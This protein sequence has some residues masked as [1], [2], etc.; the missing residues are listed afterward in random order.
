MVNM[1][2][3]KNALLDD[4]EET[5]GVI[6]ELNNF[7]GSFWFLDY[8]NNKDKFILFDLEGNSEIL[9]QQ[10]GYETIEYY[11]EEIAEKLKTS[12]GIIQLPSKI[13]KLFKNEHLKT[14]QVI[15]ALEDL[16][17]ESSLKNAVIEIALDNVKIEGVEFFEYVLSGEAF[18]FVH[19]LKHQQEIKDFFITYMEEIFDVYNNF[20]KKGFKLYSNVNYNTLA[21]I[22]FEETLYGILK[23]IDLVCIN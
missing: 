7:D 11:I 19:G 5:R 15:K 6:R 13:E 22:A 18:G 12:H 1:D 2:I 4:I 21:W 20:L 14:L 8:R 3:L 16:K 23:E 10:E 9:S 17:G